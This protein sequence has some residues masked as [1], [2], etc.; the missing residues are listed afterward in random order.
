MNL[1]FETVVQI[2]RKII[3]LNAISI[4]KSPNEYYQKIISKSSRKMNLYPAMCSRMHYVFI[5]K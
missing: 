3:Q 4:V 1:K 5:S 2:F